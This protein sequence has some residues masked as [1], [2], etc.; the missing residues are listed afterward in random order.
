MASPEQAATFHGWKVVWASFMLAVFGW[1]L[2]FYGPPVF[3][4]VLHE[5][6][7]W[8]IA[9]IATAVTVHFLVG[10]F[11]GANVPALHRRFGA[12]SITR[13][14]AITMGF[15]LIL[16]A[17][18]RE[19]WQMFAAALL[20]GCGWGGMSAAALNAIVS[21]WFVRKRPAALGMAYNGGSIGGVVFSPLWV[22]AIAALGFATAAMAIA[23]AMLTILWLLS[24]R[25]FARTPEQMALR[26]DG[27]VP[28]DAPSTVTSPLVKPLPGDL[29]W[30]D[31]RFVTLSAAMAFG[32]FAQIGLI[33]HLYSLLA[34]ALGSQQA[35]F[36]M[37]LITGMAIAGRT[38][39]GWTMPI[40]ADRRLVACAGYVAQLIGS[41]MFY[42]AAGQSVPLLLTGV[43]LFGLGFG[44]ATS[45]PPLI[46]QVEFVKDDVTRAV[47]LVVGMAQ[48]AYAFAPAT[49]GLIRAFAP[50]LVD[51]P[52]GAA[53]YMF[54]IAALLQGLAIAAFLAGRRRQKQ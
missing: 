6:R 28:G 46:A 25:Y 13:T 37:A 20:S 8:P 38:L 7:G 2:G 52:P 23:A 3:L 26:P 44:N 10:A 19:P 17:T 53:P 54:V 22:A 27:N 39:L 12:T 16:W 41:F 49:F 40:G 24:G 48:A 45:L 51:A 9:L 4:K 31:W 36:A 32:L 33:A 50:K 43:V 34:P 5:Q 35:G 11:S 30:R 1:G 21:P 14:C 18:A 29:L 15:G 42:F 47:A